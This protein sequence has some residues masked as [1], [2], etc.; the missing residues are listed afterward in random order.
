MNLS[1][2]D[3]RVLF[4]RFEGK[5]I[6]EPN[7]GCWIWTAATNGKYPRI[8]FWKK[9]FFGHRVALAV[10]IG[11][12]DFSV[13]MHK[14]DNVIC[15]NPDHLEPGDSKKNAQDCKNKGRAAVGDK[16]G[17][18]KISSTDAS[19]IKKMLHRGDKVKCIAE[20]YNLSPA[21][22]RLIRSGRNWA[23]S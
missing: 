3:A 5:Y 7:S 18:R 6:P 21:A 11:R 9:I 23:S 15:V 22:I 1:I 12:T 20:K 16:H 10:K 14:C 2:Q 13:A 4:E 17:R 19:E 8:G